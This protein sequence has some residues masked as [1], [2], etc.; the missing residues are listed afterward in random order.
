MWAGLGQA[1]EVPQGSVLHEA[2][3]DLPFHRWKRPLPGEELTVAK[4][5]WQSLGFS[6]DHYRI[7]SPMA[8]RSNP[9]FHTPGPKR[10]ETSPKQSSLLYEKKLVPWRYVPAI[11]PP[12]QRAGERAPR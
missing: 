11:T 8:N 12:A 10:T 5:L 2:G 3:N 7:T 6:F 9:Y 4:P 1:G